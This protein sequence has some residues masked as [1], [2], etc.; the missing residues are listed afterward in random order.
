MTEKQ[1][2]GPSSQCASYKNGIL[3]IICDDE[4]KDA[5]STQCGHLFC[6]PC[7]YQWLE[8]KQICPTCRSAVNPAK[9]IPNFGCGTTEHPNRHDVPPRPTGQRS[10]EPE[11]DRMDVVDSCIL[12]ALGVAGVATILGIGYMWGSKNQKK[13]DEKKE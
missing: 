13:E 12:G 3:C 11:A 6:W 8:I 2:P 4:V 1:Q 9:V 5:V 7:L 10:A